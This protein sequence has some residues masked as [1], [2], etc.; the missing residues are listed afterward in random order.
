MSKKNNV[1]IGYIDVAKF[2]FIVAIVLGHALNDGVLRMYVFS[3]HV[4]AFFFISGYTSKGIDRKFSEYL[5]KRVKGIL[6]P[7][8]AFSILSILAF[9]I[10]SKVIPTVSQVIDCDIINN[11]KVMIYGNS[12]PD[13]M[14]YNSPLWFLPCMFCVSLISWCSEFI[15]K[16]LNPDA[17]RVV[18]ILLCSAGG[19]FFSYNESIALPWHLETAVSMTVWYILGIIARKLISENSSFDEKIVKKKLIFVILSFV[20]MSFGAVLCFLNDRVVGVR[21]EH[22]GII[23]IYY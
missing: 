14:K 20:L 4:P 1:R 10:I 3:F 15:G 2:F 12:K 17:V 18:T 5:I 8:F 7:Y 21:N 22:Y 6:I 19:V 9:A 23:P 16:K 13:V 11:L